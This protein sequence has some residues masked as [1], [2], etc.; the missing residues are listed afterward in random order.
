[1]QKENDETITLLVGAG[2]GGLAWSNSAS[3]TAMQ[4]GREANKSYD[5]FNGDA[6]YDGK[7]GAG[8]IVLATFFC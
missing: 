7:D 8:K 5:P 1:M 3:L 4:H 6:L 2:G